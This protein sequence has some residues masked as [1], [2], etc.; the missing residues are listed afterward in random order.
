MVFVQQ[1]EADL[2]QK[3]AISQFG[4]ELALCFLEF[5]YGGKPLFGP[6]VPGNDDGGGLRDH[7]RTF[8][9]VWCR[10][11]R[12]GPVERECS[13]ET[14][15]GRMDGKTPASAIAEFGG[16]PQPGLPSWIVSHVGC[17]H[18]LT[19]VGRK[20]TSERFR[21][22]DEAIRRLRIVV[23]HADEV[24]QSGAIRFGEIKCRAH[25]GAQRRNGGVDENAKRLRKWR[26]VQGRFKCL[27]LSR[28]PR[29]P[30]AQRFQVER[31]VKRLVLGFREH[32]DF[33]YNENRSR[34]AFGKFCISE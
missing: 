7:A 2:P 22:D 11:T 5:M 8:G 6:L 17:Q 16:H 24:M 9:I 23:G 18:S 34:L 29:F 10:L 28:K 32:I 21:T 33:P 19:G 27:P 4:F 31:I 25:A 1:L 26:L 3:L 15:N 14:S 12:L 13:S 20:A 30:F